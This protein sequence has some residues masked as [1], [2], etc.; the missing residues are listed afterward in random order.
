MKLGV[1]SV[2]HISHFNSGKSSDFL[3]SLKIT[4]QFT[5]IM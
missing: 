3:D 1:I 5:F 4:K 2:S